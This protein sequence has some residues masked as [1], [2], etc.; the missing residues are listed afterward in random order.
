MK[1]QQSRNLTVRIF[2][3]II[4]LL[5]V[6]LLAFNFQ[7]PAKASPLYQDQLQ[8]PPPPAPATMEPSTPES[9]K[10]PG[11]TE[12]E[13]PIEPRRVVSTLEVSMAL[14]LPSI[15][16]IRMD[17]EQITSSLGGYVSGF[18]LSQT[19]ESPVG[20]FVMDGVVTLR[21][22]TSNFEYAL[23]YLADTHAAITSIYVIHEDVTN[24]YARLVLQLNDLESRLDEL[25]A[26]SKEDPIAFCD[27]AIA[28]QR[29]ET[30]QESKDAL[31]DQ[32]AFATIRVELLQDWEKIKK[33][34]ESQK[35]E[36]RQQ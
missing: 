31:D 25:E 10:P 34:M 33:Q 6:I 21:V 2:L 22:P 15:A 16:F 29:I 8:A 30:L 19:N 1:S 3:S 27:L 18:N 5:F 36:T 24:Q 4:A 14:E 20:A 23:D 11:P 17:A 9:T 26:L 35:E 28:Q 7:Q 32:I 12:F 13:K